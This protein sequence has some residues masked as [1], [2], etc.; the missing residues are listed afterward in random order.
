MVNEHAAERSFHSHYNETD[1]D[2]K[3][4][5]DQASNIGSDDGQTIQKTEEKTDCCKKEREIDY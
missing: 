4:P 1:A 2:H 5:S 3:D